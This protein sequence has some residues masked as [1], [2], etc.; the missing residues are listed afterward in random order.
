[1][2]GKSQSPNSL[3]VFFAFDSTVCPHQKKKYMRAMAEL[4]QG[5]HRSGDIAEVLEKPISAVA[6]IRARLIQKGMI[7]SPSHGG[8][9]FTVPLFDGFMKR[10]IP[11]F[12]P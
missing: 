11:M 3:P 6:P 4:G 2:S 10:T 8:T 9:A 7:Y 5:P 12:V 1:M